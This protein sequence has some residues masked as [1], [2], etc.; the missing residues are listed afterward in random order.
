MGAQQKPKKKISKADAFRK[1]LLK[2][3][4]GYKWTVH[5]PFGFGWG[6]LVKEP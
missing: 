5:R 6:L 1:E 3:M 4:P 2:I